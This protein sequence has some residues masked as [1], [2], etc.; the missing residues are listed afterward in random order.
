MSA[1]SEDKLL[2]KDIV[3]ILFKKYGL[4]K[5]EVHLQIANYKRHTRNVQLVATAVFAAAAYLLVDHENI[6]PKDENLFA[7]I[8]GLWIAISLIL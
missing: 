1:L 3:D 6:R 8:A 5:S 4:L 2:K 7:W